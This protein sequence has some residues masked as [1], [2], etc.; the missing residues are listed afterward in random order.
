[1]QCCNGE[2]NTY[3]HKVCDK[4]LKMMKIEESRELKVGITQSHGFVNVNKAAYEIVTIL[5]STHKYM[6]NVILFSVLNLAHYTL[7]R[8]RQPLNLDDE[9]YKEKYTGD[10]L[11]LFELHRG[12]EYFVHNIEG[13]FSRQRDRRNALLV[14]T[15]AGHLPEDKICSQIRVIDEYAQRIHIDKAFSPA[16]LLFVKKDDAKDY[17]KVKRKFFEMVDKDKEFEAY[18]PMK[19]IFFRCFLHSTE[20]SSLLELSLRNMPKHAA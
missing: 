6:Y 19:F 4:L 17:E 12:L 16:G 10:E 5:G 7:E 20:S 2:V 14:G 11:H 15:D 8:L 3:F 9:F 1:M 18:V 13:T